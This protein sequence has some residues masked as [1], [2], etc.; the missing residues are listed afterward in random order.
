M[1]LPKPLLMPC[2]KPMYSPGLMIPS[3]TA[4][5]AVVSVMTTGPPATGVLVGVAVGAGVSVGVAVGVFVGVAVGAV[6]YTHLRTHQT[7]LDLVC[8]LLLEKTKH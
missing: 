5:P 7:V 3:L 6:S 1:T 8:R 2:E 4:V